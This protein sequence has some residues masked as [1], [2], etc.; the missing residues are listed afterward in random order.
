ML[1]RGP[2][3]ENFRYFT[4][5]QGPRWGKL[6]IFF[7]LIRGSDGDISD[8]FKYSSG[9]RCER[10][11]KNSEVEKSRYIIPFAFTFIYCTFSYA[12]HRILSCKSASCL[13]DKYTAALSRF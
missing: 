4:Y 7:M 12:D 13:S 5:R 6:R 9:P 1:I 2:D 11:M 8:I 3:T 10:L